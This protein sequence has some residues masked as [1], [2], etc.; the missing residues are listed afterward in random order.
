MTCAL[1]QLLK[2]S[3]MHSFK[4]T[5][6]LILPTAL[7]FTLVLAL[8][9]T[10]C[11]ASTIHVP[12]NQPT[13]QQGI[14][15]ASEGD[16]VLVA[17]GIYTGE[18]NRN[19]DFHG[20]GMSL[21]S[22]AGPESTTI[23]C[24]QASR[25]LYIH[26]AEDTTTIVNGFTITFGSASY[27]GAARISNSSPTFTDCIFTQNSATG[28]GGAIYSEA[29]AAPIF[30]NCTF[31]WNSAGNGGAVFMTDSFGILDDCVFAEN[32]AG[33]GAGL[34]LSTF[35]STQVKGCTFVSN[36][37]MSG[38][39]LYTFVS[40]PWITGC[41][42]FQ[43]EA[44]SGG[45]AYI[46]GVSQAMISKCTIVDNDGHGVFCHVSEPIIG[47]SVI[48]FNSAEGIDCTPE[49]D[50]AT[51]MCVVFGNAQGDSLCGTH[52]DNLFVDPL[53][54]NMY[55]GELG[56]CNNSPCRAENNSWGIVIGAYPR[57]CGDCQADVETRSWG[58]IKRM[59]R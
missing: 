9:H 26:S 11:I 25:A 43:N 2:M 56:L 55:A 23:D 58:S 27:G 4:Q 29:F 5:A 8:L 54:C 46:Y 35:S 18:L 47:Q 19:L 15:Q 21:I 34:Y 1:T 10:S 22:E 41:T 40:E 39:G 17:P 16:T 32:S 24:E 49:A 31:T 42:F 12:A 3:P 37:A 57:A 28:D 45:G 50:P 59:L 20:T 14:D 44:S 7:A 6:S 30:R 52:T 33:N 38:G 36:H 51:N 48:A 53:L 13:I